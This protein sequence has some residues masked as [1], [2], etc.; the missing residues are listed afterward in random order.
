MKVYH[1]HQTEI[2]GSIKDRL[3][4]LILKVDKA[5]TIRY[6]NK[7]AGEVF[8]CEPF[9]LIG[10]N[11]FSDIPWREFTG[12]SESLNKLIYSPFETRIEGKGGAQ[13]II[14]WSAERFPDERDNTDGYLLAGTDITALTNQARPSTGERK[15][16]DKTEKKVFSVSAG[17]SD[18]SPIEEAITD[19]ID[20]KEKYRKLFDNANEAIFIL[21]SAGRFI[22]CNRKA[23]EVFQYKLEELS[24]KG[25]D[26]IFPKYQTGRI[27]SKDLAQK[28]VIRALAGKPQQ[29][30][31]I[32]QK[33]DGTNFHSGISLSPYRSNGKDYLYAFV[34]DL[35][36]KKRVEQELKESEERFKILSNL[37]FEGILI[38]HKG[39]VMDLNNS[40]AKMFG[41]TYEEALQLDFMK[42]I[43]PEKY[44][45]KIN[46]RK[47]Q[48]YIKPFE[49]EGKKK[50]GTDIPLEIVAKTIKRGKEQL[51][52]IAIRDITDRK[53]AQREL[54]NKNEQLL[55][56]LE[57]Y[58]GLFD[59]ASDAIYIQNKEGVFLD[60][61]KSV[62][63]MYGYDPR[64]IIGKTPEFLA[65]PGKND[66]K[67]ISKKIKLAFN[68]EPQN[69]EFWGKRKNGEIFPKEVRVRSGLYFGKKV[70]IAF[71]QDITERKKAE[72]EL[73]E[74]EERFKTLSDLSFEGIIIHDHGIVL[75][76]NTSLEKMSGYSREELIGKNVIDKVIPEKYKGILKKFRYENKSG[77][78][79]IMGWKKDG[80]LISFEIEGKPIIYQNKPARVVAVRDITQR[81]KAEEKLRESEERFKLF[82]EISFEG[83]LIHDDGIILDINTSFLR[84]SGYKREE[85]IGKYVLDFVTSKRYHEIILNQ[86]KEGKA[87]PI[88]IIGHNKTG[89]LVPVEVEAKNIVYKNKKVRMVAI[90]DISRRKKAELK[91]Q[92]QD[93]II[94]QTNRE[95][96][97][98]LYRSSHDLRGPLTTLLGLTTLAEIENVDEHLQHYFGGIKN[99]VFQ[100]MRILRKLNDIYILFNEKTEYAQIKMEELLRTIKFELEKTDPQNEVRKIYINEITGA[101]YSNQVLLSIIILY[102][103]ENAIIFKR[104]DT[105]PY[106]KLTLS[107]EKDNLIIKAEDNGIGIPS[108]VKSKVF[109]MFFRGSEQ[110]KGNGLGLYLVKKAVNTLS[111]TCQIISRVDKFT[112]IIIR[113]PLK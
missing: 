92:K 62:V 110:S 88:E 2:S 43:I 90:R 52:V 55:I 30:R 72:Q 24:G 89:K 104:D 100:M 59:N 50:D 5:G 41:Y 4:V 54:E 14:Y 79:E 36:A 3:P 49:V 29:F 34:W 102:I 51:R 64:G 35:S 47:V 101:I 86:W 91:L 23:E 103:M 68:G 85:L 18:H 109:N 66:L 48:D 60:V 106:A 98:F 42:S 21:N 13:V 99:T 17:H 46:K 76:M 65:A 112:K 38:L 56:S 61:N 10:K 77:P 53:L 111:G 107:H 78:I 26:I 31:L 8:H 15:N 9:D 87:G 40:L 95:L 93:K 69:F 108:K 73:R 33:K 25:P 67:E 58:R 32:L 7:K 94:K 63:E 113:I 39:K 83:I 6:A 97:T 27:K 28:F 22:E 44:H 81:K 45:Q 11:F 1:P 16:P 75:D 70:I 57:S 82:S 74:S 84:M 20:W 12:Q 19:S 105:E 80:S 37:S 96:N 71:A